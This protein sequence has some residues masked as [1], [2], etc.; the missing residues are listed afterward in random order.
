[1]ETSEQQE[2]FRL[3]EHPE[4]ADA[5]RVALFGE[6]DLAAVPV[7]KA[8][9][10][11]LSRSSRPIRLDLSGLQFID[12][13]GLRELL[14]AVS[15]YRSDGRAISVEGP[16]TRQV[17]RLIELSGAGPLLWPGGEPAHNGGPLPPGGEPA[18]A[19]G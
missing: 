19:A 9:L 15:G 11:D 7:L 2:P 4:A 10:S 18:P 14:A 16:L 5:T 8:R 3:E 13:T 17:S 6:L 12:S 1:M